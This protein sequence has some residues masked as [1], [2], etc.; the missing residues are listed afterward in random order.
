[1]ESHPALRAARAIQVLPPSVAE[2]IAAG[3]VIERPSSVVKELLENSIDAGATEIAVVLEDGGKGLI[4]VLDNGHGMAPRDLALCLQRHATSKLSSLEDL[5]RIHTLGFR[6]EALPSIA[7]V[8]ELSLL[9]RAA[10]TET[11]HEV[12]LTSLGEVPKPEA[13][14]FGHFLGSPHGTRIQA[15]GLFSQVPARLKFLKSQSAEVA[16]VR[17]WIERLALA[18]PGVGFR[19]VSD[20][21]NLFSLRPQSEPERVRTI[22]SGGEDY[23]V[24]TA[25]NDLGFRDRVEGS[26]HV[27][28]HWLQ[29]MSSP[30]AR[31][32]VQVVNGRALRD[33][34]LQQALLGPFRQALL[35]GQ[36]PSAAL[37]IEIDPAQLDVNV[38]PTKTEVRFLESGKV[39]REVHKLVDGMIARKG[40]PAYAAGLAPALETPASPAFASPPDT[41][42]AWA[43]AEPAPRFQLPF[44]ETLPLTGTLPSPEPERA[45]AFVNPAQ[46]VGTLF[47]TYLL[48]DLGSEL[49][50][51]DQHAA[52]ERIR[53]ERLRKAVLH[54]ASGQPPSQ[55]LLIPE[56]TR[57]EP[58]ER[59]KLERR[60]PWLAALG[61]EV[62]LF[63]DETVLFRG[64]P[65]AWGTAELRVR[66]KNLIDR[67]LHLDEESSAKASGALLDETLFEKLAS[68]ACHSSV[69]A[70]DRLEREEATSLVEQLFAVEH[71]WN[72]PHGRPTVTR[73]PRARF[74][75]WFQRRV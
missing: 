34:M 8:T 62:E 57:F 21:R 30:Q 11:A 14:T 50:L 22:L 44:T 16:Q 71:P 28:V 51:I 13:T 65:V 53:Y 56:A 52:H 66:L 39:F 67:L 31:R 26:L 29:G 49:V 17:E 20:G 32:V 60:L 64:V 47:N 70:G 24:V 75:E 6:G 10:G 7:A 38:H 72:C 68:E 42:G 59:Q 12:R 3:E 73:I 45:S 5:E 4:E 63:G 61:F 2:R 58:E 37:Y 25:A 54:P 35:P 27:R 46:Y 33:R 55:A 36:F 41:A 18:H 9:S 74:E 69:R 1:M 48:Y 19:L 23:P 15:R 43:A 40:A